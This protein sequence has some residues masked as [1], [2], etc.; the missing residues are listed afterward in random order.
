[1]I[2][3]I[4][5]WKMKTLQKISE[6][7]KPVS[8]DTMAEIRAEFNLQEPTSYLEDFVKFMLEEGKKIIN[9]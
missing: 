7:Y 1:M 8:D 6:L 5:F 3:L 9:K 4:H 2:F